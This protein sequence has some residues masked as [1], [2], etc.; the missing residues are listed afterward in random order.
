MQQ[1]G[2]DI[3]DIGGESSRPGSERIS[4]EE[5][6]RRVIPIIESLAKELDI[7]I[8][9]DTYRASVAE[10]A[11]DAGAQM[12]NDIS[13]LRFDPNM[14]TLAAKYDVP[15]VLMHMKG[16]PKTMQENPTYED[17]VGEI[18]E[19]F[20]E[21]ID[22]AVAAGIK[23]EKIII[24]PGIGF[25]KRVKDNYEILR[26]LAEFQVLDFPLLIGPSRK[27]FIGAVIP[28]KPDNRLEGTLAAVTACV[29]NDAH[30]VRVHDVLEAQ[31]AIKVADCIAGKVAT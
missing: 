6:L 20:K 22:V 24:D 9:I 16:N 21:R 13:A 30:I 25:G 28:L 27:A 15:L 19:F 31:R 29:L 3:I 8:S 11:L 18:L 4:A 14:G 7:P 17:V 12:I 5:E 10:K 26:R 23:H 2:A 1:H